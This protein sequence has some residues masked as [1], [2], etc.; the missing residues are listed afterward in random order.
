MQ[1]IGSFLVIVGLLSIVAGFFNHVPKVLIWIYQWGEPTA[2]A[3]KIGLIVI[4]AVLY[5]MSS[6]SSEEATK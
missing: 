6:K 3:I 2:W 4:G 1:R 5:I